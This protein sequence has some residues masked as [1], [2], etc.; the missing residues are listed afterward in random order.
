[1]NIITPISGHDR[2][3][4]YNKTEENNILGEPYFLRF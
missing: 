3:L 1:M 2:S 4:Q